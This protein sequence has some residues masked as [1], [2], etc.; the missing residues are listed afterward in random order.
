MNSALTYNLFNKLLKDNLAL[1]Y[2]GVFSDDITDKLIGLNEHNIVNLESGE[3]I[4]KRTSFLI[5]ECF[6]N[7]VRHG[8]TFDSI[9]NYAIN[10][11]YFLLRQQDPSIVL[12][13]GNYVA[14]EFQKSI[15]E[16]LVHINTLSEEDLKK[17]YL[18][19]MSNET[20]VNNR[21]A[22]LGLIEIARKS[23]SKIQFKF[24]E[25]N[26]SLSIFFMQANVSAEGKVGDALVLDNSISL[27]DDLLPENVMLVYKG[28][29]SRNTVLPIIEMI[30]GNLI[31]QL[32]E[33]VIKKKVFLTLVEALQNMSKHG[34]KVDGSSTGIFIIGKR[35]RYYTLTTGNYIKKEKRKSIKQSLTSLQEQSKPQLDALYAKM[36]REGS[37]T[38]HGNAGLGLVEIARNCEGNFNFN[39]FDVDDELD[40]FVLNINI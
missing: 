18:E 19:V 14:G 25:V 4:K 26:D 13:S 36:L 16:K 9:K 23:K 28:D 31:N 22:G 35:D 1:L 29:F 33:Y 8:V 38:E 32:D 37:L 6:Q 10:K 12:A 20:Y 2:F 34:E 15:Q 30:E 17:L 11:N 24:R 5:T 40:F 21:G 27:Y 39:V 3:K 7:I